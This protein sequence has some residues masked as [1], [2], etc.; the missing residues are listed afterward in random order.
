[1]KKSLIFYLALV[2]V[3]TMGNTLVIKTVHSGDCI[4]F[5][6]GY[7]VR[8]TGITTPD[9]SMPVGYQVYDFV[10]R[11]LEG[12]TVKVFTYTT[13]NLATGIVYGDDGLSFAQ[14]I[15]GPEKNSKEWSTNLNEFLLKKG[16]AQVNEQF[17]PDE[18]RHFKELEKKARNQKLGIWKNHQ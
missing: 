6:S 12:R 1:M 8:L 13:N 14:I 18:L 10:K 9:T 7:T 5:D 15:Y 17:L 2:P 4:E 3:L 16:W 11:T